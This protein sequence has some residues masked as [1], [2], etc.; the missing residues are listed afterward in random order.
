MNLTHTRPS[1]L[2]F[3]VCVQHETTRTLLTRYTHEKTY[4]LRESLANATTTTV[5]TLEDPTSTSTTDDT[6]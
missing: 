4:R 5:Q 2:L 3:C 6:K 1:F